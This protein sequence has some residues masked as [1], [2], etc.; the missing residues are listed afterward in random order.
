MS[1]MLMSALVVLASTGWLLAQDG[2]Q[3]PAKTE[4]PKAEAPQG[5]AAKPEGAPAEAP[6]AEA[7]APAQSTPEPTKAQE[8]PPIPPEVQ[9][10]LEAAR[11]AVAEAIVAAERAGLVKTTVDPPPIL[12]ILITGRATDADAIKARTDQMPEVGVSPEVFGAWFTGQGKMDGVT[13]EK[14][15]RIIPPSKGLSEWYRQRAVILAPYL[16]TAR[17]ASAPAEA[18]QPEVKPEAPKEEAKPAEPPKEEP[19]P[20]EPPKEEAKPAEPAKEEAKPAEPPKEEAKP[21]EPA[22]EEPK[23][24]EPPQ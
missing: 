4:A 16:A 22:K 18:T 12:D 24:A 14:N 6:K 1:W 20:A 13:A 3:E 7:A 9:A 19:K 10:K 5:E 21:A 23:P 11:K 2:S 15:I 17:Q 8:L